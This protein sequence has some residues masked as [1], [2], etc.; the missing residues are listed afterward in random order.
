MIECFF[1]K[2]CLI[3]VLVFTIMNVENL[4]GRISV[5]YKLPNAL[6]TDQAKILEILLNKKEDVIAILPTGYGKSL[7]YLAIPLMLDEV[8]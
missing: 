5:M 6:K 2:Y 4:F 8:C 3:V 1:I 7:L